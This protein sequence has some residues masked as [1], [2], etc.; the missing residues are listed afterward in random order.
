MRPLQT[1]LRR[2][3][4]SFLQPRGFKAH[5]RS[6]SPSHPLS[7]P[8]ADL[9]KTKIQSCHSPLKTP[10][11]LRIK[12]H[13]AWLLPLL[14]RGPSWWSPSRPA[15]T[16][17]TYQAQC[18]PLCVLRLEHHVPL[19]LQRLAPDPHFHGTLSTRPLPPLKISSPLHLS[20]SIL[21]NGII[22]S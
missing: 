14:L 8:Q 18:L 22:S 17:T 6:Q 15:L 20:F 12:P 16:A 11:G 1:A 21:S 13:Q 3:Q 19:I 9:L 4:A 10:Q 5:G 2:P 7:T